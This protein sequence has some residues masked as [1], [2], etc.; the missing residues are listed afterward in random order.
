MKKIIFSVLILGFLTACPS[1]DE[2]KHMTEELK[3]KKTEAM[4]VLSDQDFSLNGLLI[5]QSYFF[6]F[7]EKVHLVMI[8]EGSNKNVQKMLKKAGA[9]VFCEDYVF[10][11]IQWEALENYCQSGD[12]Y[13]C[14]PEI[15]EYRNALTKFKELMGP[16][17]KAD[18]NSEA[19]CN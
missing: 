14:S 1:A 2:I 15:K 12:F 5:V 6:E 10:P 18:L 3:T 19:T 16:E 8:D 17:N 4:K 11:L 13:K 7:S 9:K